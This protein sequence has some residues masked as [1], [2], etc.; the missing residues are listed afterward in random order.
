MSRETA[1]ALEAW[2]TFTLERR[3]EIEIKVEI[4]DEDNDEDKKKRYQDKGRDIR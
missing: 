4:L 2:G 3:G 1:T